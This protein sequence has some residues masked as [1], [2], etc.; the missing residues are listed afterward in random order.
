MESEKLQVTLGMIISKLIG[1][2]LRVKEKNPSIKLEIDS[3]ILKVFSEQFRDK[4]GLLDLNG[5]KISDNLNR[6]Y[7]F[8][9]NFLSSLGGS[10]L[11]RDQQFMYTAALE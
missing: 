6:I 1:E 7:G 11:S 10:N 2:L 4:K 5:G 9:D 3:D 8:Y